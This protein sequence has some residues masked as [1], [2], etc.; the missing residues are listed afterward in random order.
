MTF[1]F[2][3]GSAWTWISS[4][5]CPKTLCPNEHYYYFLSN[6]Y[7]STWTKET[8]YY[9]IGKVSGTVVN[10]DIALTKSNA[11]KARDVNFLSVH[12]A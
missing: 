9:G 12:N 11:T 4:A 8:I 6:G 1:I 3:T 10:D 5:D 2:D 7:R